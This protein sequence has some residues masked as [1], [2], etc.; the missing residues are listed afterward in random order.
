MTRADL[1]LLGI[2][3]FVASNTE[4]NEND[5]SNTGA[6]SLVV[7]DDD[8]RIFRLHRW[9]LQSTAREL[10]PKERVS[11]CLRKVVPKELV[12]VM[13]S[14]AYLRAHYKGLA[15]CGNVHTCAVCA[16]KV[17]E[18][19]REELQKAVAFWRSLGWTVIL[20]TWTLQHGRSDQLV[21]VRKA[22]AE[23]LR[24]L[25]SG[26]WWQGFS[27][28]RWQI[29]HTCK[30]N[31]ST[32]GAVNGWNP[33]AHELMF[34]KLPEDQLDVETLRDELVARYTAILATMGHYAS[35]LYG[36]DV[37]V[38]DDFVGDYIAKYGHMPKPGSHWGLPEELAKSPVK[39]GRSGGYAPFELLDLYLHG[40]EWAGAL[41]K[42]F[43]AA[44][45]HVPQLRWSKDARK[46]LGLGK[47]KTDEEIAKE[48]RE[49]GISLVELTR[50][51]WGIVLDHDVRGELLEV[52]HSGSREAVSLYLNGL[53][54]MDKAGTIRK[55]QDDVITVESVDT[56]Q[57]AQEGPKTDQGR[58]ERPI[59]GIPSP[60][61][62]KQLE[63]LAQCV[64]MQNRWNDEQ[65]E[66]NDRHAIVDRDSPEYVVLSLVTVRSSIAGAGETCRRQSFDG[67]M[68]SRRIANYF[69]VPNYSKKPAVSVLPKVVTPRVIIVQDPTRPLSPD[70]L[71]GSGSGIARPVDAPGTRAAMPGDPPTPAHLVTHPPRLSARG[72]AR[73][74]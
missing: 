58:T 13:Y 25:K 15:V 44:M 37:Q 67:M 66:W 22:L 34:C 64:A 23:A 33:H 38:G 52:A 10:L 74:P 53:P 12:N 63:W 11:W 16:T 71:V 3:T 31:E 36:I 5:C 7:Q 65:D 70:P 8:G 17:S 39:K 47:E 27:K 61:T 57:D 68:S 42:E 26:S 29:V 51:Q 69:G 54:G 50:P 72:P 2:Y 32:W 40:A 4:Y 19:R 55:P 20:V 18:R 21:M 59:H 73:D 24:R 43:A 9:A 48:S 60:V 56:V 41:F 45:K 46:A 30:G 35:D 1:A 6:S 62:P 28:D 14:E 49:K